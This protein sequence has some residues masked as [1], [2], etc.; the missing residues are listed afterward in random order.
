MAT[1]KQQQEQLADLL[2]NGHLHGENTELEP[3][4][5]ATITRQLYSLILGRPEWRAAFLPDASIQ[6]VGSSSA[7]STLSSASASAS[8]LSIAAPA[9]NSSNSSLHQATQQQQSLGIPSWDNLEE[10]LVPTT[11]GFG[12]ERTWSLLD[13]QRA[14]EERNRRAGKP[15]RKPKPGAVCGK[16]LQRFDRTYICK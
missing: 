7:S 2:L 1:P 13:V 5:R 10:W 6:Q 12:P 11:E 9:S 16:V 4:Q 3:L 14:A 15:G 8:A